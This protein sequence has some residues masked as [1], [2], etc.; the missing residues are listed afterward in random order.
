SSVLP[1][2]RDLRSELAPVLRQAHQVDADRQPALATQGED[3]EPGSE[4]ADV[5][6]KNAAS[7]QV[8]QLDRG[9]RSIEQ[10][11][12]QVELAGR[13]IRPRALES[14]R[15][16]DRDV[17]PG[18]SGRALATRGGNAETIAVALARLDRGVFERYAIRPI[19]RERGDQRPALAVARAIRVHG[20]RARE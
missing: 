18:L 10:R 13:G 9:R 14:E 16:G 6:R 20:C 8:E 2:D 7:V 3:V 12:R 1:Q 5:T 17:E 4:R 19:G 11:E 15:R